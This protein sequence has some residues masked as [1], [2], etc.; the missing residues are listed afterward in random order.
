MQAMDHGPETWHVTYARRR[1]A[2]AKLRESGPMANTM[3][4]TYAGWGQG[5]F[6]LGDQQSNQTHEKEQRDHREPKTFVP[7]G[8]E[9]H[10]LKTE[11]FEVAHDFA[12]EGIRRE[13]APRP[14]ARNPD[15]VLAA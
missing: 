14:V 10:G 1:R 5:F 7:G 13:F 15:E 3:P 6:E 9:G 8:T 4:A 12:H 2:D 11:R